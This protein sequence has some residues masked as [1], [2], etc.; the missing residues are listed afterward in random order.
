MEGKEPQQPERSPEENISQRSCNTEQGAPTEH[1]G[2]NGL[3]ILF[4]CTVV[5][6]THAEHLP[7]HPLAH[8]CTRVYTRTHTLHSFES[9]DIAHADMKTSIHIDITVLIP[10]SLHL[11]A[12]SPSGLQALKRYFW[13]PRYVPRTCWMLKQCLL[14]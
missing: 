7:S 10:I 12:F 8:A 6:C 11:S 5:F 4:S 1:L 2:P 9:S 13:I 14:N 3:I